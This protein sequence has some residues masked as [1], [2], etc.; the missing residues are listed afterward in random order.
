MKSKTI[1]RVSAL[2]LCAGLLVSAQGGAETSPASDVG[3]ADITPGVANAAGLTYQDGIYRDMAEGYNDT[4][5]VKVTIRDGRI[6]ELETA[7]KSG[8][9]AN[10]YL[11][12]ATEGIREQLISTQ[13]VEGLDAVSGATGSSDTIF[14]ALRGVA[15]QAAAG[16]ASSMSGGNN[17][18]ISPQAAATPRPTLDPDKAEVFSG[19]GSTANFRTGP[20]KDDEGTPVYSFNM[21]MANVIFDKKGRI[22]NARVDV[23]EVSTPNYDGDSMPHFSGWPGKEGYSVYDPAKGGISGVS[24]NTEESASKELSEWRTKRER[25]DEYGMN[26]QNDWYK[27]MDAYESWMIGKTTAELREWFDKYT[28]SAGRPIKANSQNEDDIKVYEGLS[29][30]ERQG[31]ADVTSMATMSLSDAHGLILEA[32]EKAYENR[33]PVD[34]VETE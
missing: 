12:K 34:G 27:Q 31:L 28:T 4:I 22:L 25:G 20:G 24:E 14:E 11:Q 33:V 19:L 13:S 2:L 7:N 17:S 15:L 1:C 8:A 29:D 21:T 6:N 9:E 18:V 23:Y 3:I 16:D 32:I 30:A 5:I 26:P 10:E